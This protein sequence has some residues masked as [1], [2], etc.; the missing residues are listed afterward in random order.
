MRVLVAFVAASGR[1]PDYPRVKRLVHRE[2]QGL[3]LVSPVVATSKRTIIAWSSWRCDR[4][5]RRRAL[6]SAGA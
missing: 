3:D 2:V 6:W 1:N 5:E 4:L